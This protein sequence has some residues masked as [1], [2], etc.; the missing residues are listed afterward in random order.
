[1]TLP[2]P[3]FADGMFAVARLQMM[4]IVRGRKLRF[5][6]VAVAL[7]LLG[8]ISARYA[9]KDAVPADVFQQGMD[10]GFFRMLVFLLPFLFASG[11]IAEEV[12][13]RTYGYVALRPVSRVALA[14]GKLLAAC[15]CTT[16]M[17]IAGALILHIAIFAATPSELAS[18]FTSTLRSTGALVLLGLAYTSICMMWGAIVVEAAGIVAALHLAVME[19]L[20]SLAPGPFRVISLHYSAT[21]LAGFAKDGPFSDAAPSIQP[22]VA[23]SVLILAFALF[24]VITSVAVSTNEYRTG[25]A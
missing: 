23:A 8:V 22:A 21:E 14:S 13:G 6:L 25:K 17:L 10:G 2:A 7:V 16:G 3:S 18:Q 19:F 12:E 5:A 9:S 4:R 20:V 15:A 1:M 24:F 11:A